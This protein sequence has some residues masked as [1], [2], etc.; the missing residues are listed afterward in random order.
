M[1]RRRFAFYSLTR[2]LT[3]V[4]MSI[5]LVAV[6]HL[7]VKGILIASLSAVGVAF[8]VTLREYVFDLSC[9]LGAAG[10]A[11]VDALHVIEPDVQALVRAAEGRAPNAGHR[12]HRAW[13]GNAIGSDGV[14]SQRARE[15]VDASL[16]NVTVQTSRVA[17]L[18]RAGDPGQEIIRHAR[19]GVYDL[20][21]IGREA[22]YEKGETD[23]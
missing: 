14:L 23:D 22:L 3:Q 6:W 5:L 11:W 15:W 9:G 7:G 18:I 19:Q 20:I 16:E 13:G 21:A 8:L 4:V 17:S 12:E 1:R 10:E 2:G